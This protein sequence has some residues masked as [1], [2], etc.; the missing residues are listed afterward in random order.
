[1]AYDRGWEVEGDAP[2]HQTGSEFASA[3]PS[4]NTKDRSADNTSH[5]HEFYLGWLRENE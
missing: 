4:V 5:S 3:N 2:L 1:M